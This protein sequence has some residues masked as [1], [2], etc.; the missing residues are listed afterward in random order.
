MTGWDQLA[1]KD[2]RPGLRD[3]LLEGHEDDPET[4]LIEELGLCKGRVRV[5][6]A[7]VNGSLHGYEIKSDRDSL[8]RLK[9]Q[10]EVYSRVMDHVT[11]VV[12]DRHLSEARKLV[13]DWWGILRFEATGGKPRFKSFR[14]AKRNP[15]LDTRALVELLWLEDAIDL[16]ERHGAAKGLTGKPRREVWNRVCEV[17]GVQQVAEAVRSS[18]KARTRQQ[19]SLRLQ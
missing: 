14:R 8:R 16:L 18:L 1:D 15:R 5:D 13:P 9:A 17:L 2:L 11:L 7:V 12:G 10:A 3:R 6:I 4:V 19:S